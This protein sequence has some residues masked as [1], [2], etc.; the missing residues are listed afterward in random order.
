M[1]RGTNLWMRNGR[2]LEVEYARTPE[3]GD[4][5]IDRRFDPHRPPVSDKLPGS[6]LI[7]K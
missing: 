6:G 5:R 2:L 3:C 1:K 7:G 4:L